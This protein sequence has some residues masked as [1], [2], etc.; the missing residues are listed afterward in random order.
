[1]YMHIDMIFNPLHTIYIVYIDSIIYTKYY[2]LYI[3][4]YIYAY[5]VQI[6]PW[7]KIRM[8]SISISGSGVYA[9]FDVCYETSSK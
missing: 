9:P 1:M 6:E 5:K 4:I 7:D 8:S 3:Y 2:I